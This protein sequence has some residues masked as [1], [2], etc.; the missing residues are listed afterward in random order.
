MS[1]T[2]NVAHVKQFNS[3]VMH[4]SQQ[5]GSRLAP[6]VR[7][8]NQEGKSQ[9]FDRIGATAAVKK[10]ARHGDTPLVN[11]PHSRRRVTLEDFEWADLCDQQ[12]K[13]RTLIDPES[14]YVKAVVWAMGRA[15]DDEI[16][17]AADGNAYS[18]EDGGTTV[19]HPNSQKVGSVNAAGSAVDKMNVEHLRRIAEKFGENDV[20]EEEEKYI[21]V[22]QGQLTNLLSETEVT[23][24][25]FNSVKALVEGKV[26]TFLG[27]KFIRTQ[28]LLTQSGTLAYSYTDGSVGAGSG[29][30]DGHTRCIAW[31]RSGLLLSTAK[32][33]MTRISERSDK[34]YSNQVYACMSIGATRMEEERVVI[35]LADT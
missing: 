8:E 30:A 25:D 29:D 21:A 20:D 4:L 32:D 28:R 34:S 1:N 17:A 23:S 26:D 19:A 14:N 31:A 5:K 27:M 10:T 15:K 18:G 6:F 3:N 35:G 22:T 33:M 2:I 13:I 16:I 7:N 9:F 12:D 24:S 11:T